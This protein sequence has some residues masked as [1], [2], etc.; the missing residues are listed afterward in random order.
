MNFVIDKLTNNYLKNIFNPWY[1]NTVTFNIGLEDH[2]LYHFQLPSKYKLTTHEFIKHIFKTEEL[3]DYTVPILVGITI[4]MQ[5]LHTNIKQKYTGLN[6]IYNIHNI[7]TVFFLCLLLSSKYIM[8]DSLTNLDIRKFLYNVQVTGE[9]F[10]YLE[11]EILELL[12]YNLY[13]HKDE[14]LFYEKMITNPYNIN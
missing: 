14:Y 6:H 2:P 8:D 11:I 5:K 10:N 7:N 4:Y 9:V 1:F 13:I 12:E 3:Y